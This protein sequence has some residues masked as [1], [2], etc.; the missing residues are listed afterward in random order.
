MWLHTQALAAP[1]IP[2]MRIRIVSYSASRLSSRS[3]FPSYRPIPFCDR[4]SM[5]VLSVQMLL[6]STGPSVPYA[7][8]I[9][10]LLGSV[11]RISKIVRSF[12]ASRYPPKGSSAI[13]LSPS[14][15]GWLIIPPPSSGV[16]GTP[17]QLNG[18]YGRE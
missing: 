16:S 9:V 12:T 10:K 18:S 6:S 17:V 1:S 7:S 11:P 8:V 5:L 15:V 3:V 4:Y 14:H 2:S 13:N